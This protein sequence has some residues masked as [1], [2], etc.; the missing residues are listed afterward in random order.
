MKSNKFVALLA[1]VAGTVSVSV[2]IFNPSLSSANTP[3]T[4][5]TLRVVALNNTVYPGSTMPRAFDGFNAIQVDASGRVTFDAYSNNATEHGIWSERDNGILKEIVHT[6]DPHPPSVSP[7]HFYI[8][9]SQTPI[10]AEGTIAFRDEIVDSP[11]Q[12]GLAVWVSVPGQ[13]LRLAATSK[14]NPE[15]IG[16]RAVI[17]SFPSLFYTNVTRQ[18]FLGLNWSRNFV[19]LSSPDNSLRRVVSQSN[20]APG[21]PSATFRDVGNPSV[22]DSGQIAWDGTLNLGGNVTS[23]SMFGLWK[24]LTPGA[25]TLVV[26]Q[27]S[28]A[29]DTAN[30]PFNRFWS[31]TLNHDGGVSFFSD[32]LT[33]DSS[34][35]V[36]IWRDVPGQGLQSVMIESDAAPGT[37]PGVTFGNINRFLRPRFDP[38]GNV[39]FNSGL[40]GPGVNTLSDSG[41]W[42]YDG[43]NV[44][45]VVREGYPAPGTE[46][47]VVFDQLSDPLINENG[48][49]AFFGYLRGPGIDSNV[50][51]RGIWAE[52]P[53]G[54]TLIARRGDFYTGETGDVFR[55]GSPQAFALGNSGHVAFWAYNFG[56]STRSGAYVVSSAAIPEPPSLALLLLGCFLCKFRNRNCSRK[57]RS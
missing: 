40:I 45:L 10:S 7:Y 44:R 4:P 19:Y 42:A 35:D 6:G 8:A 29:P 28:P 20:P 26:R 1:N 49:V 43:E 18:G 12:P 30:V 23:T 16:P 34:R 9:A 54:L 14:A 36:G 24:E 56:D 25:G 47:G 15:I 13:G 50:N 27:G 48:Q 33:S 17:D 2:L 55:I 3:S 11:G 38:S 39:V 53:E 46:N 41:L 31:F 32:L 51:D 21:V 57:L 52:G 5:A 22:N 37:E